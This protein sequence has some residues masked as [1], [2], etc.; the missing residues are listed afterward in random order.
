[1]IKGTALT[2][3]TLEVNLTNRGDSM[4]LKILKKNDTIETKND[5]IHVVF[6]GKAYC[7]KIDDVIKISI[8]TTD[9]GPFVDDVALVIT[10]KERSFLVPSEHS[11]YEK[12]IFDD[13]SKKLTIDFQKAMD[14]ASCTENA[15]F[16]LY[17][18]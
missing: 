18:K 3:C 15:E 16:I 11:L 17:S 6:D 8:F 5:E 13:I 9:Q 7:D 12:F 1:M 10:M 14:A 4:D 2:D